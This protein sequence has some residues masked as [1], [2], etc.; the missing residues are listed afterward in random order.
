MVRTFFF[1]GLVALT[2][3]LCHM[4]TSSSQS[5]RAILCDI[6]HDMQRELDLWAF[7]PVGSPNDICGWV[8]LELAFGRD[9]DLGPS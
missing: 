8:V 4:A 3:C 9:L 7:I 1:L 5:I 6:S 2:G